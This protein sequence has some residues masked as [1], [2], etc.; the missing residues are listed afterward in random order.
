[1]RRAGH[2]VLRAAID[3]VAVA[4]QHRETRPAEGFEQPAIGEAVARGQID[5]IAECRIR[6]QVEVVGAI[7]LRGRRHVVADGARPVWK[8]V[9]LRDG[10]ADRVRHKKG[11][12]VARGLG[13][14]RRHARDALVCA[15]GFVVAEKEEAIPED[16]AANREAALRTMVV[17]IG[18]PFRREVVRGIERAVAEE[19]VR[20][21]VEV[22]RARLEHH[23]DLRSRLTPVRRS[24]RAGQ[25][26]EFPNRIHR[27][28]HAHGIEF[29]IDVVHAVQREVVEVLASA[30]DAHREIAAH[31]AGGSLCRRIGTWSE[32]RQ[33]EKVAAVEG[34]FQNLAVLD[35]GAD[36]GRIT[37]HVCEAGN[38]FD[39]IRQGT[40][41]EPPIGS[42]LLIH[43]ERQPLH[44]GLVTGGRNLDTPGTWGQFDEC[45]RAASARRRR[46]RFAGAFVDGRHSRAS[47]RRPRCV[48][49]AASNDTAVALRIDAR[50]AQQ[51]QHD[52]LA[53]PRHHRRPLPGKQ[54]SRPGR[55]QVTSSILC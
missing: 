44:E 53:D 8:R 20:A 31:R 32:Q 22:V 28:P 17:R 29:G 15:H 51:Y 11:Q 23:A 27:R 9:Q 47:H 36:R 5:R 48:L 41:L 4:G 45:V 14:H 2:E 24:R 52:H 18:L 33:F 26:F 35:H 1:M 19:G 7:A 54:P 50:G 42:P 43:L 38:H 13:G 21:A 39:A 37:T 3:V 12:R 25:H 6:A 30:V 55:I 16:R 40:D 10:S 49:D 46:S 34:Q